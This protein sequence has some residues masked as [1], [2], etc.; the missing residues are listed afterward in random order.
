MV[1]IHGSMDVNTKE[2]GLITT[3]KEWVYTHGKMVED[4]MVSTEMT[5]S[6]GM[7]F[8][9]GPMEDNIKVLG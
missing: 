6:M 8:I 4:T 5:K 9:N 2:S 1:L 3:W 7:A